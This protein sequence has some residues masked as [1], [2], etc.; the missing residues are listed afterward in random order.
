MGHP[1]PEELDCA[2]VPEKPSSAEWGE[3]E[4]EKNEHNDDDHKY[5]DCP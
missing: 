1:V 4:G 3:V 5:Q 2:P